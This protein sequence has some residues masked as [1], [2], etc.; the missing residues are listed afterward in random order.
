[1]NSP[2]IRVFFILSAILCLKNG[3]GYAVHTKQVQGIKMKFYVWGFVA[4]LLS[5]SA[6]AAIEY[7]LSPPFGKVAMSRCFY[8]SDECIWAKVKNKQVIAK[9]PFKARVKATLIGGSS[10]ANGNDPVVWGNVPY[11][12]IAEC[13][14]SK[15]SLS[16]N[17]Q[18]SR[19]NVRNFPNVESADVNLYFLICHDYDNGSYDGA[20]RFNY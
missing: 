18:T 20:K 10:S 7:K 4:G 17:G 9:T 6:H 13:S 16:S 19:I 1:M 15:P 2:L 8:D 12:V 5:V 14:K 11:T 3:I